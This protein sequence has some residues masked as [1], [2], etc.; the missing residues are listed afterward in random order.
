MPPMAAA[1]GD[2]TRHCPPVI[3]R[4][5]G[6]MDAAGVQGRRMDPL[7]AVVA[8]AARG[9]EAAFTA[10]VD[11]TAPAIQAFVAARAASLAMVDEVV[12]ST[13]VAAFS[14]LATYRAGASGIEA[15]LKGIARNRLHEELRRWHGR[16]GQGLETVAEL[17]QAAADEPEGAAEERASRVGACLERLPAAW[18]AIVGERYWDDVPVQEIARRRRTTVGSISQALYRA[19]QALLAC[20]ERAHG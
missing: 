20:L 12:Q 6:E 18:R 7:D 8:R 5:D 9:D 14:H 13:Y 19:R 2:L 4:I 15:W 3:G 16:R 10:L 1:G 11:A 17:A